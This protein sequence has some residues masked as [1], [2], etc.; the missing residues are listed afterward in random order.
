MKKLTFFGVEKTHTYL[1]KK[2]PKLYTI[3]ETKK[4]KKIWM[5]VYR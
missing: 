3:L 1:D 2:K 4:K 5:Y